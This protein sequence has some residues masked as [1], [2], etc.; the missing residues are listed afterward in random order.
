ML[1]QQRHFS[2]AHEKNSGKRKNSNSAFFEHG[3]G[4]KLVKSQSRG[5]EGVEK[6]VEGP[7]APGNARN[8]GIAVRIGPRNRYLRAKKGS[9]EKRSKEIGQLA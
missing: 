2:K 4:E 9:K 3:L 5:L 1:Q 7:S 6:F 8:L